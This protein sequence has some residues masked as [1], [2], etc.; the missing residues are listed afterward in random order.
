VSGLAQLAPTAVGVLDTLKA[1]VQQDVSVVSASEGVVE[2]GLLTFMS[3]VV[4]E[5][6]EGSPCPTMESNNR[7][8]GQRMLLHG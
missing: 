5:I 8:R 7:G 3:A 4:S 2:A 1:F 6:R